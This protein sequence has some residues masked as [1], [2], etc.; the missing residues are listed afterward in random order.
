MKKFTWH[1]I[2]G[3]PQEIDFNENNL[4]VITVAGKTMCVGRHLNR[5][6]AFAHK[7]PHAGGIFTD[8]WIDLRGNVV[9]PVHGYRFQVETGRNSSGEGYKLKTWQIETHEDGIYV[10]IDESLLNFL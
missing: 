5:L 8:G 10:G 1:K 6:F 4:A 7:C 3:T 2:A 9:C